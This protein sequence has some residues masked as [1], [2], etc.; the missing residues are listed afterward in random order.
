MAGLFPVA[1]AFRTGLSSRMA[2]SNAASH[3]YA[4]TSNE[5]QAFATAAT[6]SVAFD[7]GTI[8]QP[9]F[10]MKSPRDHESIFVSAA[11]LAEAS[12]AR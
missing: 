11:R 2:F 10:S 12:V 4:G 5:A 9:P 7:P 1:A 8:A 6:G 3:A